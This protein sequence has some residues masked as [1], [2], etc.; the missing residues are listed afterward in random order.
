MNTFT[1]GLA[2]LPTRTMRSS[3]SESIGAAFSSSRPCPSDTA[4]GLTLLIW[5]LGCTLR[6][7]HLPG[8]AQ[9]A[10]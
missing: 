2:L 10:S 8:G 4:H 3:R 6:L 5:V 9:C 1:A 7:C